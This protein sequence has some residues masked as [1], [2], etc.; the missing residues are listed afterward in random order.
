MK[1]KWTYERLG[2]AIDALL[3]ILLN[4]AEDAE[5]ARQAYRAAILSTQAEAGWTDEE[6]DIHIERILEARWAAEEKRVGD[7]VQS[8][9]ETLNRD[10][11]S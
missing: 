7:Q 6:Y 10:G 9:A 3:P 2:D 4:G 5:E 11:F 8:W 1:E